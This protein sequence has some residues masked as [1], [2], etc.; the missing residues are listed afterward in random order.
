MRRI[1]KLPLIVILSLPPILMAAI[2][3]LMIY[4]PLPASL[5]E[6]GSHDRN[7]PAAILTGILGMSWIMVLIMY[8]IHAFLSAGEAL[9]IEFRR[10][11]LR[12]SNYLILGRQYSGSIE[13]RQTNAQFLPSRAMQNP[14]L[15]IYIEAKTDQHMAIGGKKPL[16]D[17]GDCQ[18]VEIS[19]LKPGKI[20][21]YAQDPTWAGTFMEKTVHADL[22]KKMMDD[23]DGSGMREI[24]VQ[25]GRI[26]LHARPSGQFNAKLLQ[27]WMDQLLELA[28]AVEKSY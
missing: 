6:A 21:V 20:R 13:G 9:E 10:M 19:A 24:C 22:I 5:P 4:I 14:L 7:L 15:D 2:A 8:V 1:Y 28:K 17:C 12:G 3:L 25:P 11:G 27:T 23:A 26:W 18:K 16:L